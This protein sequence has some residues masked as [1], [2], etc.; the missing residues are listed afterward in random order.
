MDIKKNQKKI[1]LNSQDQLLHLDNQI[2]FSLYVSSKEIIKKYKPLL[3]PF[4]LTYTSYITLLAL[5]EKDGITIK[6]LGEKLYLDSGT[7]TPLLKKLE[8]SGYVKRVRSS[9]DERNVHI[10]LTPKGKDFK[11]EAIHIPETLLCES[12]LDIEKASQLLANLRDLMGVL[13]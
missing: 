7:L 12:S 6:E 11:K 5:W 3:Q 8:S 10:S 4:G 2:C 13:K 9:A 1:H